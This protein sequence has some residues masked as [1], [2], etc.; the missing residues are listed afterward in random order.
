MRYVFQQESRLPGEYDPQIEHNDLQML[1]NKK[2]S[3]W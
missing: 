1:Q 3:W 2:Q